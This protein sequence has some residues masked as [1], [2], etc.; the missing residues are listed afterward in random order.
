MEFGN[1]SF[2]DRKFGEKKTLLHKYLNAIFVMLLV[3][4]KWLLI[5]CFI[6]IIFTVSLSRPVPWVSILSFCTLHCSHSAKNLLDR[7]K[8]NSLPGR[9]SGSYLSHLPLC[10][11]H[12]LNSPVS[13]PRPNNFSYWP[14]RRNVSPICELHSSCTYSPFPSFIHFWTSVSSSDES[15]NAAILHIVRSG[16]LWG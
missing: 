13:E 10:V 1:L 5:P 4:N 15:G 3:L 7:V 9:Y 14:F 2:L 16:L 12:C 11:S 6:Y 8:G